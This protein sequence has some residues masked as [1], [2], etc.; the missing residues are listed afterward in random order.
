ML[1]KKIA[2]AVGTTALAGGMLL[3]TAGTASAAHCFEGDSAGFSYFGTDHVEKDG[4]DNEGGATHMGTPGA[5]NCRETTG[6]PSER[7]PGRK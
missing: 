4:H 3:G 2:Y 5:S 7:A 1:L 6:S